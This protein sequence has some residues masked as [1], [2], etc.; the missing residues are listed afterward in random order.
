MSCSPNDVDKEQ[1]EQK[2]TIALYEPTQE[3]MDI[4]KKEFALTPFKVLRIAEQQWD[5][6]PA[7]AVTLSVPIE[8]Q[9]KL[10]SFLSITNNDEQVKGE[11]IIN[12]SGTVALFPFIEAQTTYKVR[13]SGTLEDVNGRQLNKQVQSVVRTKDKQQQLRFTSKGAQLSP[14]LSDGLTIEAVNVDA[15]DIDF[16]KVKETQLAPFIS[17]NFSGNYYAINEI[18]KMATLEYSARFDLNFEKNK[19]RKTTLPVDELS[20]INTPG[21][22]IVVMKG[23]GS[24]PFEY[25]VSWFSVSNIGLQVHRYEHELVAFSHDLLSAKAVENVSFQS[26]DLDG[27]AIETI[28][29]DKNGFAKFTVELHKIR[30]LIA[31]KNNNFSVLNMQSPGLDLS[32][33]QL[34]SREQR[35]MELFIYSERNLYRPGETATFNGLLRDHDGKLLNASDIKVQVVRPDSRIYQTFIWKGNDEAFYTRAIELPEQTMTG[36]WHLLTELGNGDKFTYSFKVE[37]FLPERMK[38]SLSSD[39]PVVGAVE[40][41][42][43]KIQGDY[44]YG[45]PTA[46]NR[47]EGTSI[48]RQTRT[49]FDKWDEYIFGGD[50][51]QDFDQT[52]E[53]PSQILNDNGFSEI[54]IASEWKE[55]MFPL[56]IKTF[57]NLFKSG[58]RPVTRKFQHTVIPQ[59]SLVGL[60]KLWEH[61][62]SS[63]NQTIDI[64]LI[65]V[66]KQGELSIND[67]LD[68]TLIREDR[69]YY[70]R[71]NDDWSYRSSDNETP[72]YNRV[73]SFDGQQAMTLSL[74]VEYGRYRLEVKNRQQELLSSY[75]FFAG[76]QWH[77]EN[78]GKGTRPDQVT[79]EWDKGAY[80]K[81]ETAKLTIQAPYSG[82]ALVVVEANSLLWQKHV[83]VKNGTANIEIPINKTWNRHDIYASVN[84]IRAGVAKQKQLPKRA[85]GI[86]HLPLERSHRKLDVMINTPE[87]VEPK[88]TLKAK[89]NI[90]NHTSGSGPVQL[91]L[92]A[93]DSG[94]LS[95]TNFKTPDPHQWFFAKR[96]YLPAIHDMYDSLI[97]Q[98]S[99]RRARQRFGGDADMAHGG[100]APQSEVLIVSLFSGLVNVDQHGEAE[101]NFQLPYFNGELR[102]MALA[103]DNNRFGFSESKVKV[104]APIIAEISLP[105]FLAQGDNIDAVF[106][107]QNLSDSDQ[108]LIVKLQANDALGKQH[109]EQSIHLK[110]KE[111][112]IFTLPLSV[113]KANGVGK[114]ALDISGITNTGNDSLSREWTIGLR[115]PY[116]AELRQQAAS[117]KGQGT[118]SSSPE[119]T[120]NL[121]IESLRMQLQLS[122]K[123]SFDINDHLEHLLQYPYGCLEQTTS[124]AWPLLLAT[125][126]DLRKF[127]NDKKQNWTSNRNKAIVNAIGR[128]SGMQRHDGS[129]GLWSNN[130]PEQHWLSVFATE[131]LLEAKNR[132]YIIDEKVLNDAIKRLQRY[133]RQRDRMYSENQHYSQ[134]PHHYNFAYKAYAAKVLATIQQVKLSDLRVLFDQHSHKAKTPLPLAHIATALEK[135]GDK[136]RALTAWTKSFTTKRPKKGYPGDYGSSIRDK[137]QLTVLAH[138]SHLVEEPWLMVKRLKDELDNRRWLSTQER[139]SLYLLASLMEDSDNDD[140]SVEVSL[141]GKKQILS[142]EK[143]KSLIWSKDQVPDQVTLNNLSASYLYSSIIVQGYP[144]KTP[145]PVM[146]DIH[147]DRYYYDLKGEPIDI[148]SLSTGEYTL[149]RLDISADDKLRIPDALVVELMPA[150]LELENQNLTHSIEIDDLLIQGKKVGQWLET[151]DIKHQE[152]RDDRYVAAINLR[153]SQITS[154]FYLA[155]ATTP[156]VFKV[157][158]TLV[159]D[160]YRPYIRAIGKTV[161]SLTIRKK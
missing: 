124:R 9:L 94:V 93:V 146:E 151:S 5:D 65:H 121:E 112:E 92:A 2:N 129:F 4:L 35:A 105:K 71:W 85:Y 34:V 102:L 143:D 153:S 78:S 147:V 29:S 97:E 130:S 13:V 126:N 49:L 39:A 154:L 119:L 42:S 115:P 73:V 123:P 36:E 137:T 43:L 66:N 63:P 59:D 110:P 139:Y 114:L 14:A 125:E 44:L 103:F 3:Q 76:W 22:Y 40:K 81:G 88:T 161:E 45:A 37:D 149:V 113:K 155:R 138:K 64:E 86:I 160:M 95:L 159:E 23:A 156:G 134:W 158:P 100:D 55:T 60:K 87:N 84:V 6:G 51:Y 72:V 75:R 118:F 108:Q 1:Y 82:E 79:M 150:G 83:Q 10:S 142:A 122:G 18:N 96:R 70:W 24:Y 46:K 28:S 132:G 54:F 120:E 31:K 27:Q 33:Y 145:D 148:S 90:S 77:F 107:I 157:P 17:R 111:K 140:W 116:P 104:A 50:N 133:V 20:L 101:V 52:I 109:A 69:S 16:W 141:D 74:P 61:D 98:Q 89:L 26:I 127:D 56:K 58:G 67:Y 12:D 99:E 91:T 41:L 19:R 135:S 136:K 128:I 152:Y 117:I 30:L 8:P 57:V 80:K 47:I 32:D 106:D 25:Q 21:V 131:W 11:W 7:I 144:D 48:V 68:I 15:V 38:L 53:W 62:I